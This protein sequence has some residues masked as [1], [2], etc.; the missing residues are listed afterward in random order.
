MKSLVI[1]WDDDIGLKMGGLALFNILVAAERTITPWCRTFCL[2]SSWS[3]VVEW[4]DN[5]GTVIDDERITLDFLRI[6]LRI[7]TSEE[8]NDVEE[9]CILI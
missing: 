3:G 2:R 6:W 9:L 5:S 4:M 8:E 1:G 7:L